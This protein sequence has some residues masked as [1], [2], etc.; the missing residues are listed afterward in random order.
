MKHIKPVIVVHGGAWR[1]PDEEIQAHLNGI[2]VALQEGWKILKNGG[3]GLDAVERSVSVLE[4]DPTFDAGKGS[5]LNTDGSVEM[6]AS[7]MDGSNMKA[8]AVAALRNYPNPVQIARCV[9]DKTEHILLS[10]PGCESFAMKH[11]FHPSPIRE[12]MTEREL[13]RLESVML[14]EDFRAEHA[15][16]QKR[17]TVGVVVLD[18]Q[19]HIAA[20][21]STG[22]TPKKIPGRVGDTPIIGA[23]TYAEDG[24][25][26]VS[27]TG[28]GE[29]IMKVMLAKDVAERM[30]QDV[31]AQT[32]AEQSI[33]ILKERVNGLGGLICIDKKGQIGVA[34]NTPRM[35]R[36][37]MTCEQDDFWVAVE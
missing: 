4:D 5:I 13:H 34:Y 9:M 16:G 20:A 11:G 31:D 32:S 8:G 28:W 21:T 15:F 30:R 33:V 25:G 24:V 27:C 14:D 23:G 35:A 37:T 12:L 22:G 3:K 26:G 2:R 1:I 7:I 19:G 6:D 29:A 17:G 10:G 18:E 36:G